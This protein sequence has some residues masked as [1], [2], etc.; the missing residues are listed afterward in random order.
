V[1][2][3]TTKTLRA[4]AVSVGCAAIAWGIGGLFHWTLLQ[5]LTMAA[6]LGLL[7]HWVLCVR[8]GDGSGSLAIPA[9]GVAAIVALVVLAWAAFLL[10]PNGGLVGMQAIGAGPAVRMPRFLSMIVALLPAAP[11]AA[12]AVI[13]LIPDREA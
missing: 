7:A 2:A 11:Y 1:D 8:T 13:A 3:T 5:A 12:Y 10:N 9:V 4:L 6:S